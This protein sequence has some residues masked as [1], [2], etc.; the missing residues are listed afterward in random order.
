MM[1]A[2]IAPLFLVAALSAAAQGPSFPRPKLYEMLRAGGLLDGDRKLVHFHHTCNLRIG[3]KW[4]PVVD[5]REIIPAAG[6]ARGDNRVIVFGPSGKVAAKFEYTLNR[7][8]FCA[9]DKLIV[10]G[11]LTI[12]GMS[13]EGNVLWFQDGGSRIELSHVEPQ[14]Y[15]LPDTKNRPKLDQ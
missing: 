9:G 12:D 2:R 1:R 15:P 10:Y 8:L 3:G 11:D 6:T 14:N 5:V 4:H 13:G 7:P